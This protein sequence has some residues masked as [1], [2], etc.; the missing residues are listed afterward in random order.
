M[1]ENSDIEVE[2]KKGGSKLLIIIIVVLVLAV[3]GLAA[4]VLMGGGD[5]ASSEESTEAV[6]QVKQSPIYFSVDSPFI[7]NF[8][9]QSKSAVR[10][11]QI[12]LKVMARDQSVIDAIELNLP[13]IQ[14]ELLLLLYAQDYETLNTTGTQQLQQDVLDKINEILTSHDIKM[15]LEAVYFTSF[16]M[17]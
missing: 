13:H 2:E 11:L 1:A 4:V 10:Y 9:D 6:A 15:P 7:I 12:K 3:A 17:Q 16:L 14:H 8:S 5:E